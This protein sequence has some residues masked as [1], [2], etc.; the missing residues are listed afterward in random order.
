MQE[1][2]LDLISKYHGTSKDQDSFDRSMF[3]TDQKLSQEQRDSYYY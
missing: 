1:T 2:I 3:L